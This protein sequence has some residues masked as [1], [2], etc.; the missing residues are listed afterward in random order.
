MSS[1][2]RIGKAKRR[3]S[4]VFAVSML[5]SMFATGTPTVNAQNMGSEDTTISALNTGNEDG[6]GILVTSDGVPRA[7]IVVSSGD[8]ETLK[9]AAE[10]L[11]YHVKKVSGATLPISTE[12]AD[13]NKFTASFVSD[14]ITAVVSGYYPVEL[15]LKNPTENSYEVSINQENVTD[16]MP[17]LTIRGTNEIGGTVSVDANSEVRVSGV[18]YV[19]DANAFSVYP[20]S[21]KFSDGTSELGTDTLNV[22][23]ASTASLLLNG[24]FEQLTKAGD[25]IAWW[26]A[27]DENFEISTDDVHSG[28]QAWKLKRVLNSKYGTWI[29]TKANT[30]YK[31]SFWAKAAE[32]ADFNVIIS[33]CLD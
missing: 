10:E 11:Q 23:G 8:S 9:Y 21:V 24:D 20:L 27:P 2:T 3:L 16:G 13:N 29:K 15:L 6:S 4:L 12:L 14:D 1:S 5:F 32:A 19:Q 22:G 18:V 33:E 7:S 30:S 26:N 17:T 28:K 25:K 31:I